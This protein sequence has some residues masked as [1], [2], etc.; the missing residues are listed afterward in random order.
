MFTQRIRQIALVMILALVTVQAAMARWASHV[1]AETL[2]G[3]VVV[4][5]HS[6]PDHEHATGSAVAVPVAVID[7][8]GGRCRQP[9]IGCDCPDCTDYFI[10]HSLVI[11]ASVSAPPQA[12]P[13]GRFADRFAVSFLDL[14]FA[15]LTP[16]PR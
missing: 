3:D 4:A 8:E 6:G 1:E 12:P 15:P 14:R 9:D 7:S 16:P 13:P 5:A 11:P 2:S 10:A